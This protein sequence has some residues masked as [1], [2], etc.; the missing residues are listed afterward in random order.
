IK[1]TVMDPSGAAVPEAQVFLR[2]PRGEQR[3]K[4]GKLG[5][6]TFTVPPGKY[7]MRVL[8]KG[9]ALY[10]QDEFE[11]SAAMTLDAQL[12][13][14][15]DAQV[16]NVSDEVKMVSTDPASNSSALVLREKELEALSDDP[17][18]L[19]QQLQALAGPGAGPNGGQVFIDGFTGGELPPKS[20]IRE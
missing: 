13:I 19:Q 17:D 3:T 5:E 15:A 9:F 11:V 2:G 8:A 4:A 12:S 18:E 10:Q 6:Y 16:V 7:T 14:T 1:G 20:S